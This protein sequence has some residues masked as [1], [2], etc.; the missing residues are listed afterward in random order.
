LF[1]L[2][3][4]EACE[5]APALEA[6][7]LLDRRITPA[8]QKI[9]TLVDAKLDE[10]RTHAASG[11]EGVMQ[12]QMAMLTE[13]REKVTGQLAAYET[14]LAELRKE[15]L[16][17]LQ[18]SRTAWDEEVQRAQTAS[19]EVTQQL[20]SMVQALARELDSSSSQSPR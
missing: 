6:V 5:R 20:T 11:Q 16:S 10:I 1:A 8:P 12:A 9:V 4:G 19:R 17:A 3:V 2:A 15:S 7:D 14:Q 18:E 13:L